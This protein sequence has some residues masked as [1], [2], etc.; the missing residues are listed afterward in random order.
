[1]PYLTAFVPE[2][3]QPAV[4]ATTPA[5]CYARFAAA[6]Y[7]MQELAAL[8]YREGNVPFDH[9][10]FPY[11]DALLLS[12]TQPAFWGDCLCARVSQPLA[13]RLPALL[14]AH[15]RPIL[16]IRWEIAPSR[17]E[18]PV[19]TG[20]LEG[21]TRGYSL[22]TQEGAGPLFAPDGSL[23][24]AP[25]GVLLL[26]FTCF[27]REGQRLGPDWQV[28]RSARQFF[29]FC[30]VA[31]RL[32]RQEDA[33]VTYASNGRLSLLVPEEKQSKIQKMMMNLTAT[34]PITGIFSVVIR[35]RFM[36]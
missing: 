28:R 10:L 35:Q 1:M 36:I 8:L 27:G 9:I 30:E 14:E 34:I 21:D 3:A 11:A 24:A 15:F 18:G 20:L 25:G 12:Q 4:E 13:D 22:Y 7:L 6:G 31:A 16:P 26:E 5:A 33:V 17:G 23:A 2:S 19:Q 32:G 29:S